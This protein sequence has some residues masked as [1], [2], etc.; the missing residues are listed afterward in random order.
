M[1]LCAISR[2]K[3]PPLGIQSNCRQVAIT[4]PMVWLEITNVLI[5]D[6]VSRNKKKI[7]NYSRVPR[8]VS[9]CVRTCSSRFAQHIPLVKWPF[10]IQNENEKFRHRLRRCL[11]LVLHRHKRFTF[12]GGTMKY[13]KMNE[14]VLPNPNRSLQWRQ[15][16]TSY[17]IC[18]GSF[19]R[20]HYSTR[21]FNSLNSPRIHQPSN[22]WFH[23]SSRAFVFSM[24]LRQGTEVKITFQWINRTETKWKQKKMYFIWIWLI[25]VWFL[26]WMFTDHRRLFCSES[27]TISDQQN[28]VRVTWSDADSSF[29]FRINGS[30]FHFNQSH[31]DMLEKVYVPKSFT[32]KRFESIVFRNI[33]I[34]LL[35]SVRSLIW[36]QTTID[37]DISATNAGDIETMSVD[38]AS[39]NSISFRQFD[40][41]WMNQKYDCPLQY[42][43][44]IQFLLQRMTHAQA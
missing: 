42:S 15:C 10:L 5:D 34:P 4:A 39:F 41:T 1:C 12:H 22:Q 33:E 18:I 37:N 17:T 21:H 7:Q 23:H 38:S 29:S 24:G 19:V 36:L 2:T 44:T 30:C 26:H 31:D 40:W 13:Q 20:F 8:A 27:Q 11:A 3:S 9:R 28:L 32:T 16:S 25:L 43:W 6:N 14:I 35:P